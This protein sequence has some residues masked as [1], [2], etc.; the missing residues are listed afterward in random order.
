MLRCT[1]DNKRA[2]MCMQHGIVLRDVL[3]NCVFTVVARC[4]LFSVDVCRSTAG[5][6]LLSYPRML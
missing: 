4:M 6:F 1:D 5:S 2:V 3:F